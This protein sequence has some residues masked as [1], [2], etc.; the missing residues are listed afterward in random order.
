MVCIK[1]TQLELSE[2]IEDNEVELR[3]PKFTIKKLCDSYC[4][5]VFP[6][7]IRRCPCSPPRNKERSILNV[8]FP[9]PG[10]PIDNL[11]GDYEREMA[12]VWPPPVFLFLFTIIQAA[13][14]LIDYL[15]QYYG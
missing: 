10:Q 4:E 7:V 9:P 12:K 1:N 5:L 8:I 15:L 11:D 13:V 14:F 2:C 3:K 6:T